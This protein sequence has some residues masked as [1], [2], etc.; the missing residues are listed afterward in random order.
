MKNKKIIVAV[1]IAVM[2]LI[3]AAIFLSVNFNQGVI[4][5]G[6]AANAK[7]GA[8]LITENYGPVYLVGMT[9]WPAE[10]EGKRAEVK[11]SKLE[12]I[13]YLPES[14]VGPDGAIS[15]GGE[16]RQWVLQNP[17]LLVK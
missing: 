8:I 15:Q 9:V 6:L 12:N 7:A 11:G 1:I 2:I 3:V 17:K 10:M 4:I 14:V 5:E 16:G 13:E